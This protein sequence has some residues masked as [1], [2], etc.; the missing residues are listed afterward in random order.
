M[1]ADL[2]AA[3]RALANE[4]EEPLVGWEIRLV[5]SLRQA[6]DHID[7]LRKRLELAEAVCELELQWQKFEL[8]G[9]PPPSTKP[10]LAAWRSAAKGG[11]V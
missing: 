5:N 7:A 9:E 1:T 10:A 6:A 8:G 11:G 3:L 2:P 4:H